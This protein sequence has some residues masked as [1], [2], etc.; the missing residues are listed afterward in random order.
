MIAVWSG[1]MSTREHFEIFIP[2]MP[3][4]SFVGHGFTTKFNCEEHKFHLSPTNCPNASLKIARKRPFMSKFGGGQLP[5]LSPCL[6]RLWP[7]TSG[8]AAIFWMCWEKLRVHDGI[9]LLHLGL[10]IRNG[11]NM[12]SKWMAKKNGDKCS[13]RC[14]RLKLCNL[15]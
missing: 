11:A 8:R 15:T 9:N 5:P 3:F 7:F 10:N 14:L 12:V 4:L 13:L 6:V 2:K 1:G